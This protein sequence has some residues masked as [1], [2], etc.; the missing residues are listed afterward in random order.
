MKPGAALEVR[1]LMF[2]RSFISKYLLIQVVEEDLIFPCPSALLQLPQP[3]ISS[4]ISATSPNLPYEFFKSKSTVF[5]E[6]TNTSPVADLSSVYA[7][8]STST[9]RDSMRSSKSLAFNSTRYKPS[10]SSSST[11]LLNAQSTT[12]LTDSCSTDTEHPQDH[13]RLKL[14]WDAMLSDRFLSPKVI[15]VIPFYLTSSSFVNTQAHTPLVVPLPPNSGP[16]PT[17]KTC[18]S[19]G[20]IRDTDREQIFI[21]TIFDFGPSFS[22]RSVKSDGCSIRSSFTLTSCPPHPTWDTMH[23]AKTVS[24][25]RGC[26]EAIWTEYKRMYGNDAL[27]ILLKTAPSD[28]DYASFPSSYVMRHAFEVDWRNWEL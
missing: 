10:I 3:P 16:V 5:Y 9:L 22:S 6:R 12:T 8:G 1:V 14:S 24:T 25:I 17:L 26:K 18:R 11:T 21:D 20:S 23:L 7:M 19:L 4:P 2:T 28:E 27:Q 13:T 15:S